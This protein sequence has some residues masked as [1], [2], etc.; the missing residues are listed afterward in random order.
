[1]GDS[2]LT[3]NRI[4]GD[5]PPRGDPADVT[6]G[7]LREP[8]IAVGPRG[9]VPGECVLGQQREL[10]QRGRKSGCQLH[11]VVA[12]LLREPDLPVRAG[13]DERREGGAG[14]G[15][16]LEHEAGLVDQ[17]DLVDVLLGEPEGSIWQRS[18]VPRLR[19]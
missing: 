8:Q 11:D 9:D 1:K 7:E 12:E 2:A 5:L 18:D 17:A 16:E 4:L 15:R 10:L 19:S 13:G 14:T 6:A 3:R